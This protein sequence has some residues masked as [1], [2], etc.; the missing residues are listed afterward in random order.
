MENKKEVAAIENGTTIDHI[1]PRQLF[2]VAHLLELERIENSTVIIG[3]NFSS[4]KMVRKGMIKID[5][6]YFSENEMSRIAL[7][8]PDAV[9]N[10][11]E[12]YKVTRKYKVRDFLPDRI[13]GLVRCNNPRCITNN[14]PMNT[15]FGVIDK[16][17]CLLRCCYCERKINHDDIIII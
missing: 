5:G 8:A 13:S 15:Q 12:N 9:L 7:V 10:K 6:R 1:P 3:N 16:E 2:K 14:E 17:T 4:R 11:I